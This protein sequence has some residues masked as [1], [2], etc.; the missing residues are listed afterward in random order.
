M[1]QPDW[2]W[3]PSIAPSGMVFVTSERY[4]ALQGHLLA[5]SL[6]FANV[7]LCE[8]EGGE[9]NCK[10]TVFDNIGRVRNL[11]QAPDG[12]LYVAVDGAG[13]FRIIRDRP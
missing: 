6:K 10:K 3:T 2:Q 5:G 8:L 12:Y 1:E 11:R 9:V 13:I 7:S 4:P